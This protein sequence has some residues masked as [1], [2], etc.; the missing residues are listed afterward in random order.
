MVTG[1]GEEITN[2]YIQYLYNEFHKNVF[3]FWQKKDK[4]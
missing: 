3:L 4:L 2:S 1:D